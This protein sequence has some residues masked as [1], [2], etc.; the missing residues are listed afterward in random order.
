MLVQQVPE[1]SRRDRASSSPCEERRER[2]LVL[3]GVGVVLERNFCELLYFA[4]GFTFHPSAVNDS[5]EAPGEG[6]VILKS[7][8]HSDPETFLY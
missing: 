1:S 4:G 2:A 8:F 6:T 7:L 3:G 5:G